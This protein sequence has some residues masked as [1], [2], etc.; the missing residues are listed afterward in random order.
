MKYLY[1]LEPQYD[2]RKS[3]YGKA[4]VYSDDAGHLQKS[5]TGSQQKT[6]DQA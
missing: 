3:F 6:V 1:D 5:Q 4:K 2:R